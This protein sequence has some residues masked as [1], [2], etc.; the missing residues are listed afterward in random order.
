MELLSC[1]ECAIEIL[2]EFIFMT[3][4]LLLVTGFTFS[5]SWTGRSLIQTCICIEQ[6]V[7][8]LHPVTFLKYKGINY[9]TTAIVAARLI[10]SGYGLYEVYFLTFT[11]AIFNSAF[12]VAVAVIS[13]CC[14]SVLCAL[15]HPGP[16]D[17]H[18]TAQAGRH[19]R[20]QQKKN[21]FNVIFSAL[22]IILLTYVPQGFLSIFTVIKIH[23][24]LLSCNVVPFMTSL[25]MLS[26]IITPL[27]KM[28][29]EGY[30][31]KYPTQGN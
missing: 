31:K 4:N 1:I 15:K 21:A 30:L 24:V 26:L 10:A 25:S 20:N 29:K 5:L 12:I 23:W 8:V 9:R 16:G 13:F 11:S 22:L 27:L 28:Y 7:A 17:T 14:V 19:I 6:Y 2:N 18:I 3:Y